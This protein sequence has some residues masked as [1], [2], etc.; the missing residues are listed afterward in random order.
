[1]PKAHRTRTTYIPLCLHFYRKEK[2]TTYHYSLNLL[3]NWCAFWSPTIKS[4]SFE[5]AVINAVNK[6]FSDFI[7]LAAIFIFSVPVETNTKYWSYGG[8]QRK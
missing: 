3:K 8:I 2:Q 5:A 6:A 1:M 4:V 7:L